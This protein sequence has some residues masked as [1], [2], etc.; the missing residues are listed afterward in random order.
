[1]QEMEKNKIN[2]YRFPDCED[3]EEN[4]HLKEFKVLILHFENKLTSDG[5]ILFKIFSIPTMAD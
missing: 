5:L 4:K 3:S 2:L 1:M